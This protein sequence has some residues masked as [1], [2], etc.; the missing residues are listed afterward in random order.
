MNSSRNRFPLAAKA[1]LLAAG[2]VVGF[3]LACQIDGLVQA[4]LVRILADE[5]GKIGTW[6]GA[7]LRTWVNW[8]LLIRGAVFVPFGAGAIHLIAKAGFSQSVRRTALTIVFAS[9]G[10]LFALGV[11]AKDQASNWVW[12]SGYSGNRALFA[13]A[14]AVGGLLWLN[15][16]SCRSA[17]SAQPFSVSRILV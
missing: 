14:G 4:G 13:F 2:L 3:W 17:S 8:H 1:S 12:L 7:A 10:S 15:F 11:L 9:L 5:H 16:I 6:D